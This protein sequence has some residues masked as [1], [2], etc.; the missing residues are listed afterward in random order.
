M[1][2]LGGR[3]VLWGSGIKGLISEGLS[4]GMFLRVLGPL[5]Q[6][7]SAPFYPLTID[8]TPNLPHQPRGPSHL[9]QAQSSLIMGQVLFLASPF[10]L[11]AYPCLSFQAF[12]SVSPFPRY[13][14]P[15]G[16]KQG[17]AAPPSQPKERTVLNE[18]NRVRPTGPFSVRR[19][20]V[21]C[22]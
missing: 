8:Y 21:A 9:G 6:P 7:S 22:G 11:V 10:L 14:W 5:S 1:G 15:R 18:I 20:Q 13:I 4:Q 19:L 17:F 3:A 12:W 2:F 16:Q